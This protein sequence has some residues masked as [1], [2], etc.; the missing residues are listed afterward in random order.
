MCRDYVLREPRPRLTREDGEAGIFKSHSILSARHLPSFERCL[1]DWRTLGGFREDWEG[2]I[3]SRLVL[4]GSSSRRCPPSGSIRPCS[5]ELDHV[6]PRACLMNAWRPRIQQSTAT[7]SLASAN[8]GDPDRQASVSSD[9]YTNA[10]LRW[11]S[12]R[13]HS[14]VAY[15]GASG[16]EIQCRGRKQR[17]DRER[18]AKKPNPTCKRPPCFLVSFF[19]LCFSCFFSCSAH[20]CASRHL[21]AL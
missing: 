21:P 17:D 11:M 9:N 5:L 19:L 1:L 12:R 14:K 2:M 6:Q 4:V 15:R 13:R 7:V 8:A 20:F 3:S 16:G 18:P 10:C